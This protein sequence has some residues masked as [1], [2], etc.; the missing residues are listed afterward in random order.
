MLFLFWRVFGVPCRNAGLA[1][2][3]LR[4]WPKVF[5]SK[6]GRWSYYS[7]RFKFCTNAGFQCLGLRYCWRHHWHGWRSRNS[8]LETRSR[9]SAS[10]RGITDITL[11]F[12]ALISAK[13]QRTFWW[14]PTT[15]SFFRLFG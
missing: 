2:V 15:L 11:S 1:R 7:R 6:V 3:F 12:T 10:E 5:E 14:A 13:T 8:R 4:R 9:F